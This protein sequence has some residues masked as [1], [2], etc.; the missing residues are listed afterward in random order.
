MDE[1]GARLPLRRRRFRPEA[2]AELRKL[3]AV[4]LLILDDFALDA[5]AAAESRDA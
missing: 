3:L 1:I 4:D 5:M 2:A